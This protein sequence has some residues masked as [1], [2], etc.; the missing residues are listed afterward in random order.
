MEMES[1]TPKGPRM[2]GFAATAAVVISSRDREGAGPRPAR[3]GRSQMTP[4][5]A[6]IANT[7]LSL[8]P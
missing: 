6:L 8:L 3:S 5:L 7:V 1:E 4:R 2:V